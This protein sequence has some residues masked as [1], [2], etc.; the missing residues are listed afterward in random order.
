[1]QDPTFPPNTRIVEGWATYCNNCGKSS[2]IA[3]THDVIYGYGE[4]NGDPGCGIEYEFEFQ[5]YAGGIGLVR[6]D[7]GEVEATY[8]ELYGRS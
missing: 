7:T 5:A 1:M 8:A 4:D 6:I 3:P 2:D